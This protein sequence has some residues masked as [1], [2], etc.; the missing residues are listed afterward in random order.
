[1]IVLRC[2]ASLAHLLFFFSFILHPCFIPLFTWFYIFTAYVSTHRDKL[3]VAARDGSVGAINECVARGTDI[4]ADLG[5]YGDRAIHIAARNN[6][7][8]ALQCI[9]NVHKGDVNVK[10]E[11]GNTALYSAAMNNSAEAAKE[12]IKVTLMLLSS[13]SLYLH[14]Y[15]YICCVAC[16][17]YIPVLCIYVL[18]CFLASESLAGKH[19]VKAQWCFFFL[20]IC[21]F[22]SLVSVWFLLLLYMRGLVFFF[23]GFC[24][25]ISLSL[26]SFSVVFDACTAP[27]F[28]DLFFL[29]FIYE[30]LLTCGPAL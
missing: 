28:L 30:Y 20:Y 16:F 5:N 6:H 21:A 22:M 29:L 4:N 17:S 8:S 24:V 1:M 2:V 9:I 15:I 11:Y 27:F 7:P 14:S 25:Y 13:L 26:F 18:V 23:F 19:I 10:D 12:L 3:R